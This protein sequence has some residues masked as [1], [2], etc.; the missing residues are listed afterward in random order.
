MQLLE[1]FKRSNVTTEMSDSLD[2]RLAN[3]VLPVVSIA[4]EVS[5]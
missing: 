3:K 4:D 2:F 5:G 1:T